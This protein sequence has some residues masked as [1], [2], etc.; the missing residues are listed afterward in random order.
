[1]KSKIHSLSRKIGKFQLKSIIKMSKSKLH[2]TLFILLTTLSFN[3]FS[4]EKFGST[5]NLGV[6]VGGNYGYYR[7]AG[8]SFPVLHIDYEFPVA[9]NFTLAPFV[10]F[11]SYT[12]DYYWEKEKRYYAYKESAVQLG[13]KATYYFDELLQAGPKWDFYLAGSLG[14]TIINSRWED[15][16]YGDRNVYSRTS[17]LYLDLHIGTEYHF[18]KRVGMFLDISTGVN[19]LGI[20]I[21]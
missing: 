13:G 3:S 8:R 11:Y 9:K 14:F 5:L 16:Y 6:G 4:Q 10:N 15:G 12:N 19:T 20:A 17:P 21:H 18:N 1:M 2:T 7:Y